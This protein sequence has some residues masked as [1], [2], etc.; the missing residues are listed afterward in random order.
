[1]NTKHPGN[2]K[3]PK[4]F[5]PWLRSRII[6][7]E[8][9]QAQFAKAIGVSP[10]SVSRWIK[11]GDQPKGIHLERIADVLVSDYDLVA[12]KAGYRPKELMLEVDPNS[13]EGQL[14]PMIR[15][16]TWTDDYLDTV[17]SILK[18]WIDKSP[19]YIEDEGKKG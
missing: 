4:D 1:M 16:V 8:M 6:A 17:K 15:Q 2:V 9:T 7:R 14:V 13:P 19:S 10:T 12:T 18:G 3:A 5:G 11:H